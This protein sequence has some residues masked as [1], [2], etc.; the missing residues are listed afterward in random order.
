MDQSEVTVGAEDDGG[1]L[2][3]CG[4]AVWRRTTVAR[5]RQRRRRGGCGSADI[6]KVEREV[7]QSWWCK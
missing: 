7:R 2:A 1:R 5:A 3:T 4:R 6:R